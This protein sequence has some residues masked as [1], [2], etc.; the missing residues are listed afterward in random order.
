MLP[1]VGG[2]SCSIPNDAQV[3]HGLSVHML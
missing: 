2:G 1:L 3:A